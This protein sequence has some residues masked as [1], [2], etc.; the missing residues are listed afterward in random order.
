MQGIG[1]LGSQIASLLEN[2]GAKCVGVKEHDAYVYDDRGICVKVRFIL[3]M[4]VITIFYLLFF[5][6]IVDYKNR[7]G[8]IEHFNPK[9]K[10]RQDSEILTQDCDILVLCAGMKTL[11]CYTAENVKAKIIVE[12]AHG[13]ITP[14]AHQ[15]L[16]DR[17]KL[18]LPD[19][20]VS[21]GYSLAA[22]YEYLKTSQFFGK[23]YSRRWV[24]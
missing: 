7:K 15:I 17:R 14:S 18:V 21:C 3:L 9:T 5:K 20:L 2:A 12:A 4:V 8:G 10:P 22:H 23:S 1:K 11:S 13:A 6:D 16:I 19:I 24:Y